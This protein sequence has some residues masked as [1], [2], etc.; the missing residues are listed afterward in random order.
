MR[1]SV[2]VGKSGERILRGRSRHGDGALREFGSVGLDVVGGYDRLAAA[3]K[4]AQPHIVAFGA[5]GF[6][7]CGLAHLDR[8][9]HRAQRQRVG[10]IRSGPA[11][12][13]DQPLGEIGQRGLIEKRG[14]RG[15]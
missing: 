9:R 12:G 5:L 8:K 1:Q 15:E 6:L 3:D 14:H 11:S 7:D 13:C 4:D 10:G 2:R